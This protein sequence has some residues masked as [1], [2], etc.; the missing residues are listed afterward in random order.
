[1]QAVS[2]NRHLTP[3]PKT[4]G[5][6]YFFGGK[7]AELLSSWSALWEQMLSCTYKP[8]K[9]QGFFRAS[10]HVFPLGAFPIC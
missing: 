7:L 4:R 5:N 10:L 2:H 9:I 6:R 3:S 1:M 8:V